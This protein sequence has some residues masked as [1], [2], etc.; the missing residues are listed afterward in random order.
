MAL[1]AK[2]QQFLGAPAV[3]LLSAQASIN[4]I[5]TLTTVANPAAILKHLTAQG[6]LLTKKNERILNTIE[7]SDSLCLEVETTLELVAGGGAFLP[8]LDD[9]FISDRTVVFPI[10][11]VVQFDE[12][13]KIRTIRLYWDQASLLKQVEVI[14]SRA[15]NWP[16]RDGKDQVRLITSS[17]SLGQTS[18]TASGRQGAHVRDGSEND[19]V[20]RPQT[21]KSSV[22]AT[23]DPHASLSLFQPRDVNQETSGA[24]TAGL[25]P[26]VKPA[27]PPAR[28]LTD[29]VGDEDELQSTQ[30]VY[31]SKNDIRP[32]AGA[33]KNYHPIRL[34]DE[35][36]S[37]ARSSHLSPERKKADPKKYEHFKFDER[38]DAPTPDAETARSKSKKHTSQWG[39][40]DF[41]T[42]EKIRPKVHAQNERHFGWSDDEVSTA[43][44]LY[45]SGCRLLFSA[46]P[47]TSPVKRPVVHQP[48][49]DAETHFEM[50]DD[51]TPAAERTAHISSKGG[52]HSKGLG[53]YKDPVLGSENDDE[54]E[55]ND[56]P[57][58]NVTKTV[59]NESR[60]K[61]F[62]SKFEISDSSPAASRM[63]STSTKENLATGPGKARGINIAGD[64]MG[65][66]KGSSRAWLFGDDDDDDADVKDTPVARR[67]HAD[68][69]ESQ[70][71]KKGGFWDF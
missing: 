69:A 50:R 62:G 20:S 60:Q 18:S 2:Y 51:G 38:E 33:G 23:G 31:S 56:G 14:G 57:L 55:G 19:N 16:I 42:P 45:L 13:Q 24:P 10:V 5:T 63:E 30:G 36:E 27:K 11:H 6:K 54:H 44:S 21:G 43:I 12:Q 32:K 26:R 58:H 22:S 66:R 4:Y 29:I 59:N 17:T 3:E 9:N 15:R 68:K 48:R 1:S 52:K 39:F 8:G 46:D 35:D 61:H 40:E 67:K 41:V 28:N 34:F 64:G 70:P 47:E 53:L 49:A 65:G 7:G 25:V 71:A 37:N